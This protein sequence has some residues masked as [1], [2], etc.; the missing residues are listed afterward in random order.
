MENLNL[1]AYGLQ[2]MDKLEILE[3]DGGLCIFCVRGLFDKKRKATFNWGCCNKKK[4]S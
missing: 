4:K 2:E 1:E 3:T